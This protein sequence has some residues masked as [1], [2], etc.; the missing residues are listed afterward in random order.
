MTA[1][2]QRYLDKKTEANFLQLSTCEQQELEKT[3]EAVPVKQIKKQKHDNNK[4][5]D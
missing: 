1:R 4:K 3:G 2:L 5:V